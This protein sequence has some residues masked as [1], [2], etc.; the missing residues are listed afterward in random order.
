LATDPHTSA[1]GHISD[2]LFSARAAF[3]WN[4]SRQRVAWMNASA[5]ERLRASAKDLQDALTPGSVRRFTRE[6]ETGTAR[7]SGNRNMKLRLKGHGVFDCTLE[8]F[9]LAGGDDG[10][11]V[12]E[13]EGGAKPKKSK[14]PPYEAAAKF[15]SN[16]ERQLPAGE[17]SVLQLTP[18]ELRSFHAIGRKVRRLCREKLNA[19]VVATS[20]ATAAK[21]APPLGDP[22]LPPA[23][24]DSPA[25]AGILSAFDLVV[26]LGA[27]LRI[28]HL[29]G[30]AQRL[31][32]KK[33]AMQGMA[34][35]EL[36]HL[37]DRGIFERMRMRLTSPSAQPSRDTLL[38][39]SENGGVTV[40]RAVLGVWAQGE[41]NFFLA[42]LSLTLPQ[43]LKHPQLS[44][45][46]K[47]VTSRLVA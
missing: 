9:K 15:T 38:V 28:L 26:F 44:T 41:A 2:L 21:S 39:R 30:R 10:L 14:P 43:R 32:W 20:D 5:R 11:I 29:T 31:G 47:A 45:P 46:G 8:L 42:L 23:V 34:A 17:K 4:H 37:S 6:F 27:D 7:R 33:T 22:V 13:R 19:V 35:R 18:E 36:I 25:L 40:C 24:Q 3:I 12:T 16:S 1:I